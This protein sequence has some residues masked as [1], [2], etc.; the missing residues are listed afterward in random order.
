MQQNGA[1]AKIKKS[2]TMDRQTEIRHIQCETQPDGTIE[3]Q[4]TII[5]RNQE[6]YLSFKV[7]NSER[8]HQHIQ[9]QPEAFLLAML[10]PAM[11]AGENIAC[12]HAI[13]EVLLYNLRTQL[14]P[15]L[16]SHNPQ[17]HRVNI[18]ATARDQS[19]P[20]ASEKKF[21]VLGMSCGLDALTAFAEL[22]QTSVPLHMRPQAL[23]MNNIGAFGK[24]QEKFHHDR[25]IVQDFASDMGHPLFIVESNMAK[26]YQSKYEQS[27]S[28]RNIAAAW[29][30]GDLCRHVAY[31]SGVEYNSMA[32]LANEGTMGSHEPIIFPMLSSPALLAYTSGF[33]HNRSDK[34]EILLDN[35]DLHPYLNT[36]LRSI[37]RK[38]GFVNCGTC[39]KCAELIFRARALNASDKLEKGFNLA[40]FEE[41]RFFLEYKLAYN[42]NK[43][44]PSENSVDTLRFLKEHR[45][46]ISPLAHALGYCVGRLNHLI[47]K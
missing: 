46:P 28:I 2:R 13:D 39:K 29:A 34:F 4:A 16:C 10:I 41:M 25:A 5:H 3:H 17:L 27:Y 45:A 36:C 47:R 40:A 19:T 23:I 12:A 24:G 30:I 44:R 32:H 14:I 9:P 18:D 22:R 42:A 35:N 38:N 1:P 15:Y 33:R 37:N 6:S 7:F 11:E 21:S 31:A 20:V 43:N 8:L 26:Y